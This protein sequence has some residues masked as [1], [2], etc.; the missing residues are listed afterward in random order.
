VKFQEFTREDLEVTIYPEALLG[1]VGEL[2][3]CCAAGVK[4]CAVVKSN[5]YGHGIDNVVDILKEA[6]IDFFAVASIYEGLHIVGAIDKQKILI[7]E[8]LYPG[9]DREAIELCSQ[10]GI[11]CTVSSSKTIDYVAAVLAKTGRYLSIHVN[12]DTGMGRCGVDMI[13]ANKILDKIERSKSLRLAGVYTHFATA[14]EDDLSFAH[15]QLHKFNGFLANIKD[16]IRGNILVHAANSHATIRLPESHF[17]MVRCGISIYGYS[18]ITQPLPIKLA[19]AL[20]LQAPI[21]NLLGLKKGDSVSY[22]RRFIAGR[23]TVAAVVPIG[24]ADGFWRC[25]SQK[26]KLKI[27]NIIV[28]VIGTVTMNQIAIDVTDAA[29]VRLGGLVTIIDN[30]FDSPCGVYALA[31][32]GETICYEVL[33][34]V[35]SYANYSICRQSADNKEV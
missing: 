29:D 19:P 10:K 32:L 31:D 24:Y 25:F 23:D 18:T 11:H 21:V 34:S 27:N 17:D 7:L 28:P 13:E 1:N 6:D 4:F 26:A 5:G 3:N 33:T 30:D 12:I 22:G 16:S 8:P 35:P 14:D 2:K 20:R 9:Q 15:E